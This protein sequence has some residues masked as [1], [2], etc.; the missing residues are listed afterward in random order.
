MKK[1]LLPLAAV[2]VVCGSHVVAQTGCDQSGQVYFDH[3]GTRLSDISSINVSVT[4]SDKSD[5]LSRRSCVGF[6]H[7]N[8]YH[9]SKLYSI[10]STGAMVI[11]RGV[12]RHAVGVFAADITASTSSVTTVQ[13]LS[14]MISAGESDCDPPAYHAQSVPRGQQHLRFARKLGPFDS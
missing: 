10:S 11:C 13:D 5:C 1:F 2:V 3:G 8:Q 7:Y 4:D 14:S 9:G 6:W 12:F